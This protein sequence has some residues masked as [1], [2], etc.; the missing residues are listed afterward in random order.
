E[1]AHLADGDPSGADADRRYLWHEFREHARAQVG[2]RVSLR[3]GDDGAVLRVAL[4]LLP[5]EALAV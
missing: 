3:T 2:V 4:H 1:D 5:P